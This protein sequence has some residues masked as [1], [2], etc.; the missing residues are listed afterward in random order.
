MAR[1]KKSKI[2]MDRLFLLLIIIALILFVCFKLINKDDKNKKN[3]TN[4]NQT[5]NND[6]ISLKFA[7][8]TGYEASKLD[9]YINFYNQNKDVDVKN[10][11]KLVN[12]EIDKVEDFTYDE[13]IVD[14]I[15]E[16]YYITK[17]TNRY[18]DYAYKNENL[19][20]KEIIANVNS[21]I[22]YEFYTNVK[23][24]DLSKGNLILVNKYNSL[25]SDYVPADLVYI[26]YP[27]SP[28]GGRMTRETYEA[29][30]K[31]V[32]AADEDGLYLF[33]LSPYR[34]YSLQNSLYEGYASRDGYAKADTY[35]ARPGSSEHQTG[36]AVDINS[37]D[38]SFAN[39]EEA[40]WLVANAYKYGFILRYPKGKEY[41]TGY[42]YEP[43]H[44]RY[45]GIDVAKDIYEKGITFEEYYAYYIEK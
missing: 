28:D 24:T 1:R 19:T 3:E 23:S 20:P 26:E 21:N 14:L 12:K 17:N 40:K 27:Y 43:W 5:T 13:K 34:N 10:I 25:S 44:Y 39:T 2:R 16:E 38:D 18:I 37:V 32:D 15:D 22:D 6:D 45:V 42:Q 31:L 9:D 7:S 36:L 4:P 8:V 35:S 29:F 41:I 30:K 33:S 11:V